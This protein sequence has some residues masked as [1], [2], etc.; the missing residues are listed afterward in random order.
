LERFYHLITVHR[1]LLQ[2]FQQRILEIAAPKE[3]LVAPLFSEWTTGAKRA[4]R[5]EW[6]FW[7]KWAI[8]AKR[9]AGAKWAARAEKSLSPPH[10]PA[11]KTRAAP[12]APP[13]PVKTVTST[14]SPRGMIALRRLEAICK[15]LA[16]HNAPPIVD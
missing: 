3:P 12:A 13:T 1:A 8:G 10:M 6:A 2:Q 16:E 5:A 11:E 14:L 9:T 4:A 15:S 7:T